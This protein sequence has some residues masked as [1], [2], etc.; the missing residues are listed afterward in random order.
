MGKCYYREVTFDDVEVIRA[1]SKTQMKPFYYVGIDKY[2]IKCKLSQWYDTRQKT[3]EAMCNKQYKKF[4][5]VTYLGE[6]GL[7]RS[8]TAVNKVPNNFE[9]PV[10]RGRNQY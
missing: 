4:V 7:L 1:F 8:V 6:H 5:Q 10:Y 9:G 2:G 3:V